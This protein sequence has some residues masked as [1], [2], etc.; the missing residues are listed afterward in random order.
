MSSEGLFDRRPY[1]LELYSALL[2]LSRRILRTINMLK[3][4][5][6]ARKE[7]G[8]RAGVRASDG[9]TARPLA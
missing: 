5:H 1:V 8:G 2:R 4:G 6:K 7:V 3:G 9:R